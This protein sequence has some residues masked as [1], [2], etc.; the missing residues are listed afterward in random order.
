LF[1]E[2]M[3]PL[4]YSSGDCSLF[5]RTLIQ[6]G[7]WIVPTFNYWRSISDHS[8][9]G[10]QRMQDSPRLRYIPVSLKEEWLRQYKAD[11][12]KID[13]EAA[14]KSRKKF[15]ERLSFVKRLRDGGVG[16]LAGTDS[17]MP[18][19]VAGFDLHDELAMMVE[20]GLTPL[21]ALQTATL[22]PAKYL[23]LLSSAGTVAKGRRA[24]LVLLEANPLEDIN[25]VRRISAVVVDGRFL[26]RAALDQVL[27][28]VEAS[29]GRK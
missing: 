23:G 26:S 20:G 13:E 17:D 24:D 21:E 19:T 1:E 3:A 12:E 7:T 27:S 10:P 2:Q 4:S 9:Y 22:N 18:Y 8:Y 14:Q 16:L 25:N 11:F 6:K 29:A 15:T 5:F 28:E